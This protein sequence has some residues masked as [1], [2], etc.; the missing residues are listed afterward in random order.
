MGNLSLR[1]RKSSRSRELFFV[2]GMFVSLGDVCEKLDRYLDS[3]DALAS[4]TKSPETRLNA[5]RFATVC[6]CW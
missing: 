1:K 4:A 3:Y 6:P 5:D 2:W